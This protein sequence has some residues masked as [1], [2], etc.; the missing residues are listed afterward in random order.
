MISPAD[1]GEAV[2]FLLRVSPACAIPELLFM[3]SAALG[4]LKEPT[5]PPDAIATSA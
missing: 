3:E 5:S 1:L 4:L 2:R